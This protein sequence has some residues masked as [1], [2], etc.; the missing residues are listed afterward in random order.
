MGFYRVG[1]FALA[2]TLSGA[3]F[4]TENPEVAQA[5]LNEHAKKVIEENDAIT[6]GPSG[7]SLTKRDYD[8]IRQSSDIMS[9]AGL[10]KELVDI[11]NS[12]DELN[13]VVNEKGTIKVTGRTGQS[14]NIDVNELSNFLAENEINIADVATGFARGSR[15][16]PESPDTK[17][18]R[19]SEESD[20]KHQTI[21][22]FFISSSMPVHQIEDTLKQA[23][24]WGGRVI[25]RGL[26]PQDT[27]I[28]D[29]AAYMQALQITLYRDKADAMK[30]ADTLEDMEQAATSGIY[31]DPMAFDRFK[32]DAVP[33][34]VYER[35]L[36]NGGTV[37]GKAE[38]MTNPEYLQ[39]QVEDELAKNEFPDRHIIQVGQ[40][41]NVYEVQERDL[42]EEM[43][44]RMASLDLEEMQRQA[45]ERFWSRYNFVELPP[46]QED[47]DRYMDPTVVVT[48]S[49]IATDGT[50]LAKRGQ[51]YNPV[52]FIPNRYTMIIFDATDDEEREFV[53]HM[54]ANESSG[55]IKL[56]ATRIH[57][58]KGFQELADLHKK[59]GQPVSLLT[60]QIKNHF[61]LVS[62]P[63]LI[64]TTYDSRYLIKIFGQQTIRHLNDNEQ[65]NGE[66]I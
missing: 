65:I 14:T 16:L 41:G 15:S 53:H 39:S 30:D 42:I 59:Y 62:S 56:I 40:F 55:Q 43:K 63:S 27:T 57:A 20:A 18:K 10:Q 46:A 49:V 48:K 12:M 32:I 17:D 24:L 25:L 29:L 35:R 51:R 64:R 54:M 9:N 6:S 37:Y 19:Y 50:V 34:V 3:V 36:D 31:L 28:N 1:V 44:A 11:K 52:S 33:A 7:A 4:A 8:L 66:G 60:E 45:V 61:D 22:W 21:F 38:G 58:D 47:E 23:S 26:R 13:R 2:A 5:I